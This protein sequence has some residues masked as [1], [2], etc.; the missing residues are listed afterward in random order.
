MN[1]I[2]IINKTE[3]L[4]HEIQIFGDFE[5]PLFLAK[6]VANWIGHTHTTKMLNKIDEEE[7]PKGIIFHGGQG[8]EMTFLT[9][10]GLYEV[11]MQ[12]RKLI[13]KEFKRKIKDIL[14]ALRKGEIKL[15]PSKEEEKAQ[16]LLSI[17]NGGQEGVLAS[18]K[19]TELEVEEAKQPLL[20]TI[21]EQE[22]EVIF[23]N[24]VKEDNQKVYSWSEVAKTLKLP[25]GRNL[26]TKKLRELEILMKNNEPYQ[27]YVDSKY[28]ILKITDLGFK[29][30]VTTRVTGKGLRYLEKIRPNIVNVG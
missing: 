24:R 21:K 12:S 28:F 3:I 8:R 20:E 2:E 25:F 30:V 16:L 13:A 23:A 9:E 11:L 6:D 18:R 5:N 15:A 4:G 19:L 22:P 29:R 17:Y 10:D 7:K 27:R 14:K 1:K 26:L